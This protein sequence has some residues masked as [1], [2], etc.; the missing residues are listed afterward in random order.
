MNSIRVRQL[1]WLLVLFSAIWLVVVFTVWHKAEHEVEELF[2]AELGQLAATLSRLGTG[3]LD[4]PDPRWRTL[5]KSVYGHRYEKKIAFQIWKSGKLALRSA[6]APELPMATQ[7]G[8]SD[9]TLGKHQWRVFALQSGDQEVTIFVGERHDVRAELVN[10]IALNSLYPLTLSLPVLALLIWVGLGRGLVPLRQLTGEVAQ[11]SPDNLEPVR[12]NA[13]V[14]HEVQPLVNALNDLLLRL[15]RA[16]ERERRFTAD[17]AHELRT[18]LASIQTQAQVA[19]RA[20]APTEQQHA[21]QQV[22]QGVNRAT[23]LT[24][25]LLTLARLDPDNDSEPATAVDLQVRAQGVLG[26]LAQEAHDRNIELSLDEQGRGHVLGHGAALDI[27][28]RNLAENAIRYTPGGGKVQLSIATT[29]TE[30]RL[31]CSDSGP[32]IPADQRER[33]FERFYRGE[34]SQQHAGSGLGLSIVRRIAELHQARLLLD[35]PDWG[36]GLQVDVLFRVADQA[37]S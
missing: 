29:G 23:R 4:K 3:G 24:Q 18:P 1:V 33:V 19:L 25:Q 37:Q 32:G 12:P 16:F 10:R 8:Y 20:D 21:L 17:A 26:E 27:L 30:V 28:I 9:H 14:P 22:V 15:H 35:T 7:A 6:N 31:R 36:Y 13:A 5:D 34:N 11:R 2:D